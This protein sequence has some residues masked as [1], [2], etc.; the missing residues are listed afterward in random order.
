MHLRNNPQS[1]SHGTLF[2]VGSFAPPAQMQCALVQ[3]AMLQSA[4]VQSA[5]LQSAFVQSALVQSAM[6]H[7]ALL[8]SAMLHP[9]LSHLQSHLETPSCFQHAP[10]I[11]VVSA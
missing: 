6:L 10:L 8:H 1:S 11:A 3:S 9:A 7:P 2:A 5:M 4:F